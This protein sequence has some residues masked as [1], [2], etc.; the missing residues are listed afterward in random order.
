VPK[1]NAIQSNPEQHTLVVKWK[2]GSSSE[3]GWKILR[4]SCPCAECQELHGPADPLKLKLAPNYNMVS[5]EYVGNYA[6]Q[7]RWADGHGSGIFT[8]NY[9]RDLAGLMAKPQ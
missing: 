2:D 1:S 6:V 3:I 9:L 5:V 4:D 8:W 7:P